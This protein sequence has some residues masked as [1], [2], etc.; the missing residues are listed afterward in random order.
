MICVAW[1]D[2]STFSW[3]N[4][5]HS[6]AKFGS[7]AS[8]HIPIANILSNCCGDVY[9]VEFADTDSLQFCLS[10][11]TQLQTHITEMWEAHLCEGHAYRRIPVHVYVINIENQNMKSAG[12]GLEECGRITEWQSS[13][14]L[15]WRADSFN[16]LPGIRRWLALIS[17]SWGLAEIA[18]CVSCINSLHTF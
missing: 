1:D 5:Q 10:D 16:E 4:M 14:W 12:W 11:S 13:W 18:C 15:K 9:A 2:R 3:S 6:D 8:L 7:V 17:I